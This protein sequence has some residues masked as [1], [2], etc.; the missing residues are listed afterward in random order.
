[1]PLNIRN[2]DLLRLVIE[3]RSVTETAS[4]LRMSQPAVSKAV[5]QAEEQL[6]FALFV[7]E[8][9][10]LVPTMDARA[11]LP[12]IIRT[13]AAVGVL[14]RLAEDLQGLHAGIVTLAAAPVLGNTLAIAAI[15]RLR[16]LHPGV[17]VVMQTMLNHQV[18][19]AVADHRADLGLALSPVD[20]GYTQARDICTADLVCIVPEQHPLTAAEA[21]GPAELAGHPMISFSRHQPI[22]ALIEDAFRAAGVP[23]RIAVEVTQ[24]VTA[25]ALVEAGAGITI[26]DGFTLIA[27]LPPGLTSRPFRPRVPIAARLLVPVDRP[28]SRHAEAFIRILD[29]IVADQVSA[30]QVHAIPSFLSDRPIVS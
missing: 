13:T 4:R 20:D 16:A 1:M 8:R 28:V 15:A 22:G 7:R 29:A 11:L 10:R 9:G 14:N 21:I 23:W 25:C 27:G 26:V 3:T 2:L 12:E 17:D 18:V 19:E 30:G 24:S 6:G 5:H